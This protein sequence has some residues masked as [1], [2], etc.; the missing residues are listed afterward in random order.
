MPT[1]QSQ[2]GAGKLTTL[3]F[4]IILGAALFS[5]YK[6][7]PF[8]YRYF[9]L[10]NQ[11]EQVIRIA[12]TLTDAEVR[13]K[14]WY[15]IQH[16]DIPVEPEDLKINRENSILTVSL[17]WDEIFFITF[18]GKDYDL[19]TFHFATRAEGRVS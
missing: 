16:N 5:G 1:R 12:S 4:A 2:K 19:H 13:E 15:H 3:V 6:I 14:L 8:Y 17:E 18:R 9:E 11:M 10:Q 7:L